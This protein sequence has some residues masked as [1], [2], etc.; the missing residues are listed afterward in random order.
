[1]ETQG[2]ST[3]VHDHD[4]DYDY[5]G[6]DEIVAAPVATGETTCR[7][8]VSGMDCGDCAKTIDA[9][10]T[11]MP[12]VQMSRT[13]FAGGTVDI[14]YDPTIIEPP[15]L[16]DRIRSLGYTIAA[17]PAKS[18]ANH[19]WVFDVTGM[20]CADCARTIE[21]GVR[22]LPGVATAAINFGA[23]TLTVTPAD[24]GLQR[25]AV[26]RAV[27]SAGYQATPR[28]ETGS[29]RTN[30]PADVPWWRQRRIIE[31]ALATILWL[32]GFVSERAG[33]SL[34][35]VAVPFVGAMILAGYPV[36]RAGWFALKARRADMNLLMTVAAVGAVAIGRW[37]EGSSV[38]ILFAIGLTLQ[39]LTLDR[40]RRALQALIKLVPAEARLI[41]NGVEQLVPVSDVQV[42]ESVSVR[43]G[44]RLPVDGLIVT[45]YTSVDQASIT[46]E[47]IPVE[48]EPGSTVYAGSIN[49]D[50]A[51]EVRSTK[52]ATDTTLSRIIHLVEEAQ[53]SKAP[54][55]AFV[56]KFAAIYTP[57]VIAAA[58]I[59][60]LIVPVFTGDFQQWIFR[61]LILLVVACPCAL[62]I[63]TPVALVAAIGSASRRGVLFKGG[64][65][66]ES[67]STVRAI[68][69]D[70][71]G[72]LTEGR[73]EVVDI[74]PFGN[75][76][77]STL[78]AQAAAVEQQATHPIARS[79]VTEAGR[80]EIVIPAGREAQ[81][82]PGKG[83]RATIGNETILVGSRRLFGGLPEPVE[84]RLQAMEQDGK[85]GILIGT[86]DGVTGIISVADPV[87]PQS[88]DAVAQ[89]NHLGL[90]TIM[91]TGDNR[92]VAERIG[93]V[94]GVTDI[95]AELL[96]ADKVTAIDDA[97][98]QSPVA[99]VGDGVNDAPALAHSTVGIAMGGAGSD[100]AIEAADVALMGDELDEV[101]FAVRLARNTMS[102]IRQNITASIAVKVVFLVLTFTGITNLW[103]A[104]LADTG[105]ALI[106][107]FNSLRLPRTTRQRPNSPSTPIASFEPSTSRPQSAAAD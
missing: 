71:T 58:A 69:F 20:D 81:T 93:G 107:T 2:R 102:I 47:S 100:V 56:D 64:M 31:V 18:A 98:R 103:L 33:A 10:L 104:V 54:A 21:S 50:G 26:V 52:P 88:R 28:A 5:D 9:S 48:V 85:T 82:I 44:D 106:V 76:S 78:L 43:P 32:T 55:Q 62:V 84:Q 42:G 96:P 39:N 6:A 11:K 66:I 29:A 72:T 95:R 61:A 73:P 67:L 40:T 70:K 12:G 23:A 30:A 14:A 27:S 16:R 97:L 59:I 22:R 74:V 91:L 86:A 57:I 83:A 68:A 60:G 24:L 35:V 99:M 8:D 92:F 7:L 63:S 38:L 87:R 79:I 51:I 34:A 90:R 19:P 36:A 4:H 41:R 65:A 17:E 45:G 1:M 101:P 77:P 89:L 105:M 13:S 49:G 37:D 46:G 25:D 80:R 3:P 75:D 15:A 94:V 53:A